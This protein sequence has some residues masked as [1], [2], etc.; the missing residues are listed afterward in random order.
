M[1]TSFGGTGTVTTLLAVQG[2]AATSIAVQL[3]GKIVLAGGAMTAPYPQPDSAIAVVRY[4][5]NGSLD[6]TF[7]ST[8]KITTDLGYNSEAANAIVLQ[9]DGKIVVAGQYGNNGTSGAALVRY[10]TNGTLDTGFNATGKVL[11]TYP[12][13]V[14]FGLSVTTQ[15][16]D[17]KIVVAGYREHNTNGQAFAVMRFEGDIDT[18]GDGIPDMNETGTG[19]YIS[20][21][22]TGTSPTLIDSDGD[23]LDDGQEV[24]A[25]HSNPGVKDTDHDGFEDGFEVSTG[26]SPTSSASTPEAFSTI[27]SAVEYRF[28]SALGISYRI[29]ASTDL[30]IWNT[31]ETDIIG[32]GGVVT[33]FYSTEGQ[34]KRYFR[35]RRN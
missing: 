26:Y 31:I 32:T 15:R 2:A 13:G 30:T 3:D 17:G 4:N 14:V 22:D 10:K 18:D 5:N 1:D 25:Y 35:S 29:E 23:G 34:P 7:N 9:R 16:S 33:R 21:E 19:I 12:D 20:P 27:L 28:N 8:G 24:Y 11:V 6:T